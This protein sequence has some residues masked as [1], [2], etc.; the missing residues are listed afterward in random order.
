MSVL[1]AMLPLSAE[2]FDGETLSGPVPI[3]FACNR[4]TALDG[5][6]ASPELALEDV[7]LLNN[8][9]LLMEHITHA[10]AVSLLKKAR[11]RAAKGTAAFTQTT[12]AAKK[13]R[14]TAPPVSESGGFVPPV[15]TRTIVSRLIVPP[16]SSVV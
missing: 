10:E 7:L 5:V 16:C 9:F 14:R 15:L 6:L 1:M 2:M 4:Q 3:L 11:T 13:A 8:R 12:P